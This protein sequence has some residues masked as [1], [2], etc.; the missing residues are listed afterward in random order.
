LL[1]T[2][3]RVCFFLIEYLELTLRLELP[4]L[5]IETYS[6][7]QKSQNSRNI[8]KMKHFYLLL[9]VFAFILVE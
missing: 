8:I 3:R 5:E 6:T 2:S 9:G 7:I 1:L 4:E